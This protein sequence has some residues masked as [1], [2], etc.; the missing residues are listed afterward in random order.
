MSKPR[1][2]IFT[3][4][5]LAISE[6]FIANHCRALERY[7]Y[8]LVTLYGKADHHLDVPIVRLAGTDRPSALRRMAFRMGRDPALDRLIDRLKPDLVHAH[9][10]PNGVFMRPYARRYGIPLVVTVHG[11]DATRRLRSLSVYDQA[12]RLGSAALKRDAAVILPVSDFLRNILMSHGFEPSRLRTHYLG[13]PMGI[14]PPLDIKN[15]PPSI[16]FVGRLVAKKGIDIVLEAFAQ[17][18]AQR[19]DAVLHIVGDGPMRDVVDRRAGQIGSVLVHGAQLPDVVQRLMTGA[20]VL[21][22]PSRQARDGDVEGF[23]LVLAEAQALGL[24]VVTSN[25]GGTVETILPEQTGF[26]VDPTDS[27]ALAA[28]CLRL[29]DDD[30]LAATMGG[31]AYAHARHHFDLARQTRKLEVIYDDVLA[32]AAAP[33][34]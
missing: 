26:A 14:A 11:L 6:T 16:L 1:V 12:Y 13:V 4:T 18:K 21:V 17:L 28:A 5:A 7:D 15:N 9:Y 24:P 3:E 31:Q 33:W 30:L 2:L 22:L 19:P 10:L 25:F 27:A 20:R 23:G 32:Q 34:R 29:L 8:V